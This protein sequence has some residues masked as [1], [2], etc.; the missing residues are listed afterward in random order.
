MAYCIDTSAR[1]AAWSERYPIKR[2][3]RFWQRLDDLIAHGRL[4]APDEVRREIKQKADG[5]HDWA[6]ARKS[7]F[8][9]LEEEIQLRAKEILRDYPWLLKNIPGKSP[10]DPFVIALAL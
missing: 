1:I 2:V 5:L 10:A 9:D 3:P 4:I 7:M 8:V 6:N